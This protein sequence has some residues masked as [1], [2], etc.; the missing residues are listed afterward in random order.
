[1]N[2]DAITQAETDPYSKSPQGLETSYREEIGG[3][4]TW[5]TMVRHY[6]S[7]VHATEAA[8]AAV[9][10]DGS[11][12]AAYVVL[13]FDPLTQSVH[14]AETSSTVEHVGSATTPAEAIIRLSNPSK[15]FPHFKPLQEQG[16]E[17]ISGRGDVLIFRKV[18][19]ATG[20]ARGYEPSKHARKRRSLGTRLVV[21]T[22]SIAGAAYA[23]GVF[24]EY[25]STRGAV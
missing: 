9:A 14:V 25:V 3:R 6:R 20:N 23:I 19:A 4:A 1:M 18:R 12:A 5:P 8:E 11:E 13:A 15:F 21:G 7:E 17:I 10:A 16:Y 24:G 2:A 22:V